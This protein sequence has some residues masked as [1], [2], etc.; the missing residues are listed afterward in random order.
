VKPATVSA[1]AGSDLQRLTCV[2]RADRRGQHEVQGKWCFSILAILFPQGRLVRQP[3]SVER[4]GA[5]CVQTGP[6]D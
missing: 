1:V 3:L 6:P 4:I 2:G 5:T